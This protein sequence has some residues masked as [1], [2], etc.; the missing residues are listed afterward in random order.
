MSPLLFS[1]FVVKFSSLLQDYGL[2]CHV[3]TLYAGS[4]GYADDIA[5]GILLYMQCLK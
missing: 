4:F 5:L 1:Y 3:G 2:G